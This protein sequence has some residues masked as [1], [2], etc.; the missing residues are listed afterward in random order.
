MPIH[1]VVRLPPERWVGALLSGIQLHEILP[2]LKSNDFMSP[3][4]SSAAK[5]WVGP[6]EV[7]FPDAAAPLRRGA[8]WRHQLVL[9]LALIA[10]A[11]FLADMAGG[12]MTWLPQR[13]EILL[14]VGGI[15]SW[16]WGWFVLQS[17]RAILYRYWVFPR[18]RREAERCV[19]RSG[20]VP[21]VTILALT[22]REKPWITRAVF[23]SVFRELDSLQRLE[24]PPRVVVV[25]GSEDDDEEIRRVYVGF[26]GDRTP[27]GPK[28]AAPELVLLREGTG[29]RAAIASGLSEIAAGTPHSDGV[30]ILMD[31]DTIMQHGLLEKVL[32]LFR[33]KPDVSAVTTNENGWVKGPRWFAEWISLRFGLR[34]RTMCSVALSNK[35]LCLTGRL[36]VFRASVAVDPTFRQQIE[37]DSIHHWLWDSFDML[38]GDDK[39]TWYWLAAHGRRMLYVPDAMATTLEVV[40]GSSLER[41]LANIRRW[42][43]NS[44]RH[45]WRAFKLGPRKLGWFCWYSLL[46]QRLAIWTVLIGPLFALLA[47]GAGHWEIASGYLLWVMLSRLVH[48]AI[49]WRHGRRLSAF[50]PPLQIL[51]D[52]AIALIKIWIVFH[53]AKQAWLNRGARTL[54]TTKSGPFYRLR[55]MLAHYLFGF[56]CVATAILVGLYTGFLSLLSEGS[57]FLGHTS[58]SGSAVVA[59]PAGNGSVVMFG[60]SLDDAGTQGALSRATNAPAFRPGVMAVAISPAQPQ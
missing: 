28:P 11:L 42:S 26:F 2:L 27:G 22:D 24:R 4:F 9:L 60:Q 15:G 7:I 39:S 13:V 18:V 36:S 25:T 21:E 3:D 6:S 37:R 1:K 43:G 38:S 48:S 41:A 45:S 44:L 16:R 33:L 57:L 59:E 55:T 46:D 17:L 30:V 52:W 12:L 54:D 34:H 23:E 14:V 51:S 58:P 47:L 35:L 10:T 40:Q 5:S 19:T 56:T 53:P 20:P 32:P 8:T 49:S 31:G 50:Y 29:K